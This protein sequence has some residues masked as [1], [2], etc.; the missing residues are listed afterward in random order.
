MFCLPM[1][2][3]RNRS[4]VNR[5]LNAPCSYLGRFQPLAPLPLLLLLLF[6][7]RADPCSHRLLL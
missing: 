5:R 1:Q 2:L 7:R 4:W 3:T 6:R